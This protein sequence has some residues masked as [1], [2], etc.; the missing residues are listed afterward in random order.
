MT[1]RTR[2]YPELEGVRG[3][4]TF[5]VLLLHVSNAVADGTHYL[6]ASIISMDI[7]F[8]LS[9]FLIGR[10]FFLRYAGQVTF[11]Y[12]KNRA[13]RIWPMYF[14]A[15]PTAIVTTWIL[16][17]RYVDGF[18][19]EISLP[20]GLPSILPAFFLQYVERYSPGTRFQY[21]DLFGHSWSVALEEQFYLLAPFV[22]LFLK[23][24]SSSLLFIVLVLATAA[25]ALL[26]HYGIDR[27]TLGGRFL[28]FL[29]GIALAFLEMR[30]D[31]DRVAAALF[32]KTFFISLAGIATLLMTPLMME[33][34][35]QWQWPADLRVRAMRHTIFNPYVLSPMISIGLIGAIVT[36]ASTGRVFLLPFLQQVGKISYSVYLL[37]VPVVY[38]LAPYVLR[39]LGYPEP[40]LVVVGPVL[41]IALAA[42]T[43]RFI[44][45]PFLQSKRYKS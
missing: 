7:F 37:H 30:T 25:S 41:S 19:Q 24:R 22:I 15:W 13:L 39:A 38:A 17:E 10:N 43:F 23:T 2:F 16:G 29:Y 14:V 35:F 18:W 3:L 26:T 28:P 21:L 12:F 5:I 27:A 4:L 1:P 11:R 6:W 33:L 40:W 36:G 45:T 34:Y 20:S 8:C 44:E 9:G 42:L 32:S 31:S